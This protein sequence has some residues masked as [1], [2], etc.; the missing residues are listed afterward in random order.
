MTRNKKTYIELV[1]LAC[2]ELATLAIAGMTSL[3]EDSPWYLW[4]IVIGILSFWLV[5][6][7]E[8]GLNKKQQ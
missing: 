4:F 1:I 6:A 5:V 3:K 8:I 2:F 7:Y